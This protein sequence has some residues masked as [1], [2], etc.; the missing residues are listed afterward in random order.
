[1]NIL[2][3]FSFLYH[4]LTIRFD[5]ISPNY[6]LSDNQDFGYVIRILTF[7]F[8]KTQYHQL[9]PGWMNTEKVITITDTGEKSI[10]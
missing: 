7:Y 4:C 6:D 8:L 10:L 2:L 1:M 9:K 3:I 5:S